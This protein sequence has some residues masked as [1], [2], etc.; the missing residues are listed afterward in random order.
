VDGTAT[1]NITSIAASANF[2]ETN[3]CGSSIAPGT[4]CPVLVTFSPS[5]EGTLNGT[6]AATDNAA[7]SPQTVALTGTCVGSGCIPQGGLFW[8]Q[9]QLLPCP[10][11]PSF[12]LQ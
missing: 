6:L 11:W 10:S 12:V 5:T 8:S 1:L 9:C 7:G 4:S 3:T 2:G